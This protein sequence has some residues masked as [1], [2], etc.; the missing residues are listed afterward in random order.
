[1]NHDRRPVPEEVRNPEIKP[2]KDYSIPN[3]KDFLELLDEAGLETHKE[4]YQT[5]LDIAKSVEA[6]GGKVL[7]V[8]GS[9]R[10]FLLGKISK[11]FDVEVYGLEA[12][13][14]EAIVK[15]YGKVEEVGKAFGVLKVMFS[16]GIDID[17]SLPRRD[18]K[19]GDGHKDFSIDTDPNMSIEDAARRRDF[20]FNSVS[21]NPM[22]GELYDPFGGADDIRKGIL[23]VTDEDLFKDDPLRVLRAM[24]FIGRFDLTI[25]R[26][27]L[28]VLQEMAPLLEHLPKERIGEEWKKLLLKSE[29]PSKGLQA[30]MDMGALDSL[31]PELSILDEIEQEHQWHPEGNVWKHT[32]MVVDESKRVAKENKLDEDETMTIVLAALC[33]DL[34]KATT[35]VFEEGRLRSHGHEEAGAVPTVAFL[36]T[37]NIDKATIKKVAKLVMHHLKPTL[38]YLAEQK[39]DKRI[40]DGSIRRL[41]KALHPAT[42]SEL[43]MVAEADHFG[44]DTLEGPVTEFPAKDWLLE[45]ARQLEVED[46]KPADLTRGSD[47][48]KRKY[49]GGPNIGK[50]IKLS[51]ELRDDQDYT[52]EMVLDATDGMSEKDAIVKLEELLKA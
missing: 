32:L 50:L 36:E 40:R 3:G 10:D 22:T 48:M 26:D 51:N 12:E 35:T 37:L 28:P 23:K 47:W 42:I 29:R 44:R 2:S 33:H 52:K 9:V 7:L 49:R 34:G 31:H 18:S 4:A 38:L 45:R 43:V 13:E 6:K 19:V 41:A 46:Q 27:S 15:K 11:D 30:A 17:V 1:M 20:T 5:V 39:S 16:G 25:D 24:Q 14:I 21:A 8:G